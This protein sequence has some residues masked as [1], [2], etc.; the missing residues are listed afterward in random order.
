MIADQLRRL[1]DPR[2]L[3]PSDARGLFEALLSPGTSELERVALLLATS[4]RRES[5]AELA[6]LAREMRKR[7]RPFRIPTGDGAIDLCGSGGARLPSFNVST[8]SAFVVAAAGLPVVKHGN[9]SSRGPCGSSDLLLAL[10][11]PVDRSVEF[12]RA[13]Y[14]RYHLAFLHAP[15]FHPSTRLVA[16]ARRALGI[17]TVFNRLG[18][19]SNPAGVRAQV[20][21]VPTLPATARAADALRRLGVRK[22][23]A[24]SSREGCDEFSPKRPTD[25][26][27]WTASGSRSITVRPERYLE[28]DERAGDW[29]ALPAP[30]A[31]EE[32][33]RVLAGGGGARRGSVLLTS[34][35]ALWVGGRAHSLAEGV[36]QAREALD[37]GAAETLLASLR[38]LSS[39][40]PPEEGS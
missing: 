18:P 5:G 35:A 6:L 34:G 17:P 3:S 9:R 4:T 32:A 14:R 10:G 40:F 29:G 8:V 19:L 16:T 28:T 15:L 38:A 26:V 25:G 31:A 23:L 7:A 12:A 11:L 33:E 24:M 1:E 22:G 30:E 27:R 39:R 13:S 36:G 20:V 2:T 37:G 21:G